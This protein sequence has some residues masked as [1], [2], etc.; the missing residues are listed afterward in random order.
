MSILVAT[1]LA[2][3]L[4]GSGVDVGSVWLA[5]SVGQSL[6]KNPGKKSKA[7]GFGGSFTLGY[8]ATNS[9]TTTTNFNTELKLG[10]NTPLW[11][12][13]LDLQAI[14]AS[15]NGN[16]TA[17]QY[18]GAFQSN[19]LLSR[20]SYVF[21]YLGYIHDRFSGYNY[22]ASE[23]AG[24]G[25]RMVNTRTQTLKL[26]F[27]AGFTQ[28][29]QSEGANERSVAARARESYDWQ[30][31]DHGSVSQSLTAEKSDFNLYSQF[32]TK[33]TAQLVGNL[34]F[35]FAY[36]IQHNSTVTG[37]SPQTTSTTSV[38]IQYAFGSIFGQS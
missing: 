10:Y 5:G 15:T 25:I 26:E 18:F 38:S 27:G 24:Y 35:V 20:R 7:L 6:V 11:E 34:A 31:S 30:F 14:G 17:E 36:T 16:T 3:S 23:V 21:G 9:A 28:A 4:L 19:R 12:H 2:T 1:V 32:Q 29:R 8:L 22:Q 33:V 13:R 37:D